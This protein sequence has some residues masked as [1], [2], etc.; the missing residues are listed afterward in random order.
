MLS[1]AVHISRLRAPR[2]FQ[3]EIARRLACALANRL[4]RG[5]G[6]RRLGSAIHHLLRDAAASAAVAVAVA[7]T[8]AT[9]CVAA[10]RRWRQREAGEATVSFG[11]GAGAETQTMDRTA[12]GRFIAIVHRDPPQP[13]Q[14]ASF[15]HPV[16]L[17]LGKTPTLLEKEAPMRA[18]T[19]GTQSHRCMHH[20]RNP[21][22]V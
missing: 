6:L 13:K 12:R 4:G 17:L 19:S 14:K 1:T 20:T 18:L 16:R 3:A 21:A 22:P 7:A 10:A 2:Q 5:L 9:L 11:S 8:R 15:I